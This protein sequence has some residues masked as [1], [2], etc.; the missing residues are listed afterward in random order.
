M[1]AGLSKNFSRGALDIKL[2]PKSVG[3]FTVNTCRARF[4][5]SFAVAPV[6]VQVSQELK[7]GKLRSG[8]EILAHF[9]KAAGR[10]EKWLM[11]LGTLSG[12]PGAWLRPSRWCNFPG[13]LRS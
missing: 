10:A 7:T 2:V 4:C 6:V 5:T 1:A 9:D 3:S 13:G 8:G 12:N 11:Q